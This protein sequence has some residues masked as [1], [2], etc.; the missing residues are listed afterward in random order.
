MQQIDIYPTIADLLHLE[1]NIFCFGQSA[2]S[3]KEE[4]YIYYSNGEY[5]LL[6]GNYLS[7]YKEGYPIELYD[8]ANDQG[9]KHNI[10][11]QN[12]ERAKIHQRFTEAI[13]QQYN[14]NIISN[15]THP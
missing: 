6:K 13:I 8:V 3:P 4:F 14:N 11:N 2:F 7:K 9:L 12:K 15:S 10:A 1:D 5:M